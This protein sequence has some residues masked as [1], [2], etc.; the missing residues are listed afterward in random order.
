MAL[1]KA[2]SN[3][4]GKE[5]AEWNLNTRELVQEDLNTD[6]AADKHWS[7]RTQYG[8][9]MILTLLFFPSH[10]N[11]CPFSSS[12]KYSLYSFDTLFQTA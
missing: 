3:K 5:S 2:E 9:S 10:Y 12:I 4:N 8:S 1:T 11:S 6:M 7:L